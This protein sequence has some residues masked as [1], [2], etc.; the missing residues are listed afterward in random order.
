MPRFANLTCRTDFSAL[1]ALGKPGE[2]IAKALALGQTAIGFTD[3]ETCRGHV[4]IQEAAQSAGIRPIFGLKVAIVG[5]MRE[6]PPSG[7]E[8]RKH[9]ARYPHSEWNRISFELDAAAGGAFWSAGNEITLWALN[10]QGLK[11]LWKVSSLAHLEGFYYRPRV[12]VALLKE[13]GGNLAFGTGG[14][15]GLLG[16][17]V[18]DKRP[19]AERILDDAFE[20]FGDR[21]MIEAQ[22]QAI[23][24]VHQVNEAIPG[25]AKKWAGSRVVITTDA[26]YVDVDHHDSYQVLC[27]IGDR[28][29][30][31]H[32]T[33]AGKQGDLSFRSEDAIQA[34]PECLREP[35]L[36]GVDFLT[37]A[38]AKIEI[39]RINCH[40]PSPLPEGVSAADRLK[41]LCDVGWKWRRIDD[42][43]DPEVYRQRLKIELDALTSR[44][45]DQYIL[46][47]HDIYEFARGSGIYCG[48]GRG[49]GAGSLINYLL[50]IT[51]LDPVEHG[52][53]FERFISPA[54]LDMPDIDMDFEDARRGEVIDY[55]RR[56]YGDE[57]VAQ[58]STWS[59]LKGPAVLNE[60][61]KATGI[62]DPAIAAMKQAVTEMLKER[63]AGDARYFCTVED[64]SKLEFARG[65]AES[66]PDFIKHC[67]R[68]E[69][70]MRHTGVHAAA[71]IACPIKLVD[72]AP[73][74][75]VGGD[76]GRTPIAS[77]D[78]G[79]ASGVKLIKL[80][81]L[82]LKTLAVLR[83]ACELIS[84]TTGEVHDLNWLESLPLQDKRTLQAFT[85]LDLHGVFQFD[86]GSARRVCSGL[87]FESFE[88]ISAMNALNR[89]GTTS[90]GMYSLFV[91][92][93]AMIAKGK[94]PPSIYHPKVDEITADAAGVVV[95]QEHVNQIF[96][97]VAGFSPGDADS[98]R[99][100]ISKSKG[101][102]AIEAIRPQFLAG[103]R[104]TTP[105]MSEETANRLM[106]QI[107]DFGRYSFNKSH[108]AAYALIAYWC[109]WIKVRYPLEFWAAVI[110]AETQPKS[111]PRHLRHAQAAGISVKAADVNLSGFGFT[112]DREENAIRSSLVDLNG[113]GTV[114]AEAIMTLRPFTNLEDMASRAIRPKGSKFNKSTFR[115]L[116]L[117]GA[118]DKMITGKKT[119]I[120]DFDRRWK[121]LKS[122]KPIGDGEELEEGAAA[123][124]AAQVSNVAALGRFDKLKAALKPEIADLSAHDFV[125][126]HE[127]DSLVWIL[128]TMEVPRMGYVG[129]WDEG[130]WSEEQKASMGYGRP[131]ATAFVESDDGGRL[132]VKF[133]PEV[134]EEHADS[135]PTEVCEVLIGGAFSR[136]W[137]GHQPFNARL[138]F[139]LDR[140][141]ELAAGIKTADPI[142]ATMLRNFAIRSLNE[143]EDKLFR[144]NVNA[145]MAKARRMLDTRDSVTVRIVG[146][147]AWVRT[148]VCKNGK[149]MAWIG[150]MT[151]R[152]HGVEVTLFDSTWAKNRG[153][154]KAGRPVA[155][156]ARLNSRGL[157]VTKIETR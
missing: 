8:R 132:R 17:I 91:D 109:Q 123:E 23:L 157:S 55:I 22:P 26:H 120:E 14:A 28:R 107:V 151:A 34:L 95:Y 38:G 82:G 31:S 103:C 92:R 46:V 85:D 76:N 30:G 68:L 58:I 133:G 86:T 146:I 129:Q 65:F 15:Y 47:V 1:R 25:L 135:M 88:D 87:K 37:Q 71:V 73:L 89:P 6:K 79:G 75:T 156:S 84:E 143:R 136:K 97:K 10:D 69:G 4:V 18:L 93:K 128:G 67:A 117:A 49:S 61:A 24:K 119:W 130:D 40:T 137:K 51:A 113:V 149:E 12:D 99:R 114:A 155:I 33:D 102:E 53:L 16:R 19:D 32:W 81:V 57:Y 115:A 112:I 153:S 44:G 63:K 13:L 124:L 127:H 52:L 147:V 35:A 74:E 138:F 106:D 96:I 121:A 101:K 72:V 118:L 144:G 64:A 140:L 150:V 142:A 20:C 105:D 45:F 131:T 98:L 122:G 2:Y 11:D 62:R 66:N 104:E 83:F 111:L 80:D 141:S 39:D 152:R 5:N 50:G 59:R 110:S 21:F 56:R 134:C 78:M 77:F 27:S 41:E 116:L 148:K 43:G 48:P 94:K 9:L 70:K 108:A 90:S 60:V 126:T 139:R 125:E 3:E 7:E 29:D 100:K 42:R 54:R 36:A 145:Y 154:I